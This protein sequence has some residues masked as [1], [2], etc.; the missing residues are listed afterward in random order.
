MKKKLILALFFFLFCSRLTAR[1]GDGYS[2]DGLVD[3]A[4]FL[5]EP[6]LELAGQLMIAT[7]LDSAERV[8]ERYIAA[9]PNRPDGYYFR[10]TATSWRLF[11]ISE[12]EDPEPLKKKFEEELDLSRQYAER[13]EKNGDTR[14]AGTL[15]LGAIYGQQALLAVIDHR[16][17]VMAPLAKRAWNYIE[18]VLELDPD[19]YDSYLGRGTYMYITGSLPAA[20]KL[21]AL[22][23]GFEGNKTEG[24]A[25]IWLA[26]ARGLY[27]RDASLALLMNIYS[28]LEEPNER[29]LRA[30]RELRERYPDNPLIHWRLGD[31]LLR[32]K[33]YGEAREVYG[34]VTARIEQ[35]CPYYD[36][37]MFSR[38]SMAYRIALSDKKMGSLDLARTGFEQIAAAGGEVHPD[39]IRASSN[40]ELGGIYYQCEK[41]EL[42]RRCL[43]AVLEMDDFRNSRDK[44]RELL[45]KIGKRE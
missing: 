3:R 20:V 23:Y 18:K 9:N 1:S 40:L 8:V 37:R 6:E 21:L 19:Y 30:A 41:Y 2:S 44:A 32:S 31:I 34:E 12:D 22:V 33:F 25:N 42:A 15:Y 24:L 28:T 27:S 7:K 35:G 16:W 39:W 17:L 45:K 29:I 4:H 43:E 5:Y 14:F 26:A 11:L 36:N 38:W 10:A 13:A